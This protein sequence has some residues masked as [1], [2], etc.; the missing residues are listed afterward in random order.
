MGKFLT[1]YLFVIFIIIFP[2]LSMLE[3]ELYYEYVYKKM[4]C[5]FKNIFYT[6]KVKNDLIRVY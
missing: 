2:F 5:K 4:F 1:S 3:H 6:N